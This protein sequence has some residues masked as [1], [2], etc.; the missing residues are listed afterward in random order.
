MNQFDIF[1][2]FVGLTDIFVSNLFLS[3][4]QKI[5]S[6]SITVLR[7]FRIIRFLKF[8]RYWESFRI[9]I[10]NLLETLTKIKSLSIL[11]LMTIFIYTLLGMEFFANK[12]KINLTNFEIDHSERGRSPFF[13]FDK[14]MDSFFT[15]FTVFTIDGQSLIY[16]NFYRAVSP[17]LAT[18]WWISYIIFA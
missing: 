10:E 17:Y 12:A 3:L 7:G 18:L 16:Y 15:T 14:F 1:I 13:H 6:I 9:L 8:T 2:V 11:I 5:S 4:E